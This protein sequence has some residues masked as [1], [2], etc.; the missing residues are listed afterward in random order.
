MP[1]GSVGAT[2][3]RPI[4]TQEPCRSDH[5]SRAPAIKLKQKMQKLQQKHQATNAWQHFLVNTEA[6]GSQKMSQMKFVNCTDQSQFRNK[7]K[8]K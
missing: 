1:V 6:R 5:L 3:W 8:I 2:H 4:G 7:S